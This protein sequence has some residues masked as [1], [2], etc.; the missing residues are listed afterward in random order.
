[1]T[2]APKM[3]ISGDDLTINENMRPQNDDDDIAWTENTS[4]LTKF[5]DDIYFSFLPMLN[6]LKR[7]RVEV[8]LLL[9]ALI[10]HLL[11]SFSNPNTIL[12]WYSSD[13]GFYYFQVARNLS[14]GQGFTFD[15]INP[16]NGFHPLWLF[17]ITPFF[18]FAQVDLLL[19]LR[20]LVIFSAL[21]STGTAILIYRILRG[22]V[23][24]YVAIL[25]GLAWLII[26][27]IHDMNL[28]SGVEASINAFSIL[29]FWNAVVNFSQTNQRNEIL[30]RL[31]IVGL[32]G[33]LA[34]FARL[35]N[36]F[37]IAL[38]GLWLLLK[39]WN[40]P[41]QK[42][43]NRT[44]PLVWRL[45][46]G[47]AFAAPIAILLFIYI[48]WNQLAFGTPT[49][50]SGQVKV[51]WGTLR[52]TVYGFPVRHAAAFFGQFVTDHPELGPWSLITAPIYASAESLLAAF[53]Q[54]ITLAARRVALVALGAILAA[55][56]AA[57]I[58]VERKFL[59]AAARRL[60]LLAFFLGCVA[61]ISYYK[62]G[63]SVA[64]QPWY[65]VAENIFLIF[66]VG[67]LLDSLVRFVSRALPS[68]STR[69][70][71]AA[72][73]IVIAALSIS[74]LAFI[75]SA[76]RA[77]G[78]GRNHFYLHRSAWLE[79]HT[80]EGAR[81]A[82]TGAGNLAYFIEGRTIVNMDGLM[83]SVDYLEAMKAGQGAQFLADLEVDYIFGNEYILTETNP[84]APMLEGHLESYEVYVFGDR[85]LPL[86]RFVP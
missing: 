48:V 64:Q 49:P 21:V 17:L 80:E 30:R 66:V 27:R 78:D 62:L 14:S 16:T 2:L 37:L 34:I 54:G 85:Q 58:W 22:F 35:D 52:N 15:G 45:S 60:S 19:P 36:V 72:G 63:G 83:N 18:A 3:F 4:Q 28:H 39:L 38:G 57:L 33:T 74:F 67:L 24:E 12:D 76:V 75:A 53:G 68:K 25:A 51:W 59:S 50:I 46:A 47:L 86:W 56:A 5:L 77:P 43:T 84:Y 55:S 42:R 70:S 26:P 61:Q 69:Y 79:A 40:Q 8:F 6:R 9:L 23:S 7:Y 11:I 31:A 81:I 73:L 41:K 65:W 13:D 71:Y 20:L 32:L 10:P 29:L 1:M 82:I 44:N